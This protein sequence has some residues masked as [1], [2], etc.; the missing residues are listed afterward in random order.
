MGTFFS[1]RK[2]D[3]LILTEIDLA[4]NVPGEEKY[5]ITA[6]K[7]YLLKGNNLSLVSGKVKYDNVWK[8]TQFNSSNRFTYYRSKN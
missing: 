1:F 2:G 6:V 4:S 3:M 8:T 7:K 5:I